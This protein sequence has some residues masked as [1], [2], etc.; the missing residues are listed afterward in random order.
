MPSILS[1]KQRILENGFNIFFP[2]KQRILENGFN[3]YILSPK[4]TYFSKWL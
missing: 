1:I 3:N 2:L 4:T